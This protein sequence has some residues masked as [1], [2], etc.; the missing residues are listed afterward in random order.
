MT[1]AVTEAM[2]L[3]AAAQ[4]ELR[5]AVRDR[6]LVVCVGSGG[7][8]KTTT[9]A[10]LGIQAA[11][12]GRRVI[13]VTID[14]A[15]RLANSLGLEALGNDE[16]QIDPERFREYGL[17]PKGTL[18]AMMLDTRATFDEVISRVSPDDET[19]DRVLS[20][21]IYKHISDT[22]SASHDYMAS[23]KLYDLYHSGKYDLIVLD[24]PPMKNAIDFLEAGGQLARFLDDSIISWF[25]KPHE[26]GRKLGRSLVSGTG[27]IVYKLLGSVFGN[28]FLDEIAEFFLA[29]KDLLEGFRERAEAVSRLLH[30][31]ETTRFAVVCTPRSVS[32]DEARY[33][34]KQLLDRRMPGGLFIV[35]QAGRYAGFS[36]AED[37]DGVQY[38]GRSDRDW[39]SKA[40]AG[41]ATT[42]DLHLFVE[43][44]DTHLERSVA[45][46]NDDLRAIADLRAFA[47]RGAKVCVVPRMPEDVYDLDGLLTIDRHLFGDA[48]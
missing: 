16:R 23:E 6:K 10:A 3:Q 38:L 29:T 35:N 2:E 12:D 30:D 31:R 4:D 28:D 48:A 5:A 26:G 22:L 14:P 7:V 32:M 46:D 37:G 40:L 11:L 36:A 20:N 43:R 15:K 45:L 47:G 1:A 33:F 41:R 17:E 18:F 13:V 34:H 27:T 24:T 9:A 42:R 21:R 25:L 8:G 44:L 39:I 19:R